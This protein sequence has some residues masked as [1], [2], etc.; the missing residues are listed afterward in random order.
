MPKKVSSADRLDRKEDQALSDVKADEDEDAGSN[1]FQISPYNIEDRK[2]SKL[3][4]MA[5]S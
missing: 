4:K 5:A 2:N 1:L 3:R